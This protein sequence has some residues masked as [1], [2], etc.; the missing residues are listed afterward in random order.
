MIK[1]SIAVT[2]RYDYFYNREE[3]RN[4][5]DFNLINWIYNLG[6]NPHLIP[7][8]V[9]YFNIIKKYKFKGFILSGGNDLNL[10]RTR[11]IL[12]NKI[13][14]YSKKKNLPVLGICHGM[15]I[16]NK[17]EGGTLKKIKNH[18]R[19]RHKLK[20]KN[21]NYPNNVNSFHNHG[22]KKLGRNFEIIAFSTDNQIEAIKHKK[23]NWLGWMWHP[24][25]EK[26]FDK[27]LIII[28]KKLFSFS[29]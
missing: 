28:A 10:K 12:E 1:K 27:K 17:Y 23:Y 9:R 21:L 8:D 2:M 24:E 25:R 16:M 20:N 14:N 11:T 6:Y 15:Q 18:I 19:K 26:K 29:K 4:G 22:I 5:I 13:L 3:V 7:N